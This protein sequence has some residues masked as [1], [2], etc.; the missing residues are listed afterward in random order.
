MPKTPFPWAVGNGCVIAPTVP[1]AESRH[2]Q[3]DDVARA[4]NASWK[5]SFEYYGGEL[6]AESC[7]IEDCIAIATST[8]QVTLLLGFAR[9][10]A[11]QST[12]D[13]A[14]QMAAAAL[15]VCDAIEKTVREEAGENHHRD[16]YAREAEYMQ[17]RATIGLLPAHIEVPPAD[18]YTPSHKF[19]TD[20]VELAYLVRTRGAELFGG[21]AEMPW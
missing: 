13:L 10:I 20:N 18:P 21:Y 11:D 9:R 5:T 3:Y 1:Y 2:K 19:V 12:D 17:E 6:V 7:T 14:R 16:L 8:R 15:I 4:R